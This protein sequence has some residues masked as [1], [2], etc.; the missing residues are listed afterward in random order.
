MVC[1]PDT[2]PLYPTNL[3]SGD[4]DEKARLEELVAAYDLEQYWSEVHPRL[5]STIQH[6]LQAPPPS[7]KR[8][9]SSPTEQKRATAPGSLPRDK[10]GPKESVSHFLNRLPPSKT[11]SA[12]LGPWIWASSPSYHP[13]K[14]DVPAFIRKATDL[15]HGFEEQSAELRAAHEKSGAKTTAPLT[16]KLNPL[17]RE[18]EQNIFDIARECG[19]TSGKWM[20]FPTVGNVDSC[21]EAV[22]TALEKGELG[23]LAKVATDDGSDGA[24]LICVYTHDFGDVDDVKRVLRGLIDI[25]L[26]SEQ[27]RP[28]Y[29]KCDAFTH[30]DI[31]SKNDYGLKASMF[32]SKDVVSGNV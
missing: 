17:R 30:L 19:V 14:E 2:A 18:L 31:K 21:W 6:E 15:L 27:T 8:R 29:Y 28:I 1:S 13:N 9:D 32:S 20:L 11:T 4:E 25:D 3:Q 16:R 10:R 12:S 23:G 26:V 7:V 5:L 22:V 24:R